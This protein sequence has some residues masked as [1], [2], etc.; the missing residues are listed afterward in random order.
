MVVDFG[1]GKASAGPHLLAVD[2]A[3]LL[4]SLAARVGP[5]A[6]VGS[7][8]RVLAPHDLAA[9]MPYLQPLA[10]SASTRKQVSKSVLTDLRRGVAEATGEEPVPL[11]RLVRVRPRTA[12]IVVALAAAFYVLLPQLAQV[13]DSV[14]AMRSANWGWL[15]VCGLLSMVTYV[16]SAIAMSGGVPER[17]PFLPTLAAQLASSFV[18]RVTPAKVGGLALNVRYLQKAGVPPAGAVTGV[19]LNMLAGGLVHVLLTI[20][21]VTLAGRSGDSGFKLPSGS[22]ALVAV[23]V[24]LA[25][26]GAVAATR[27]GRR[28][29]RTHVVRFVR[30]SLTS[31]AT[32]AHSPRK[33]T[34]LFGGSAGVTLAYAAGLAAAVAAFDGGITFVQ[35]TAVYLGSSIVASRGAHSRRPGGHGGGAGGR[36]HRGGRR[37]RHRG[38]CGAQLPAGHLLAADPARL[39][40]FPGP[41]AP[42]HHLRAPPPTRVPE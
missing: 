35:V 8:A 4:A 25:I 14:A 20:V 10:L 21:F 41:G 13:G 5:E 36:A 9:T 12:I 1:F 19:G 24:V 3:E 26:A 23:V 11:E 15:A 17:L 38:G 2:R 34:A 31:L 40:R 22:T 33:L 18:N 27:R 28:L 30:Q 39:G 29:V 16:A 6:A 7:A 32:L 42:Q 37:R